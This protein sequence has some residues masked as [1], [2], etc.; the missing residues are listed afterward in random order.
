MPTPTRLV[1][2]VARLIEVLDGRGV[3]LADEFPGGGV[4]VLA[5]R[6]RLLGL[7]P[8]G[9]ASC[10]GAA[11]LF[12]AADGEVVVS[13]ARATDIELL[14]AWAGLM[15]AD[16]RSGSEWDVVDGIVAGRPA[17]S[18]IAAAVELGLP[19]AVVGEVDDRGPAVVDQLGEASPRAVAGAR[20]VNLGA[21]WAAPLAANLLARMGADV[22]A[23]ESATR[24]DGA[25]ATPAFFAALRT[26]TRGVTL[27][28]ESA[29]GRAELL[30]WI[31][32]ADIVIEGSR[33]RALAQ[34]GIAAERLVADA[35]P[36]VWVS[37]TGYGRAGQNG[38]RVGFGDDTAAAGGLVG[39][40]PTAS[41][42]FLADAIGDPLT[43]LTAAAV[44]ADLLERGGRHLADVALARVC[45]T[46]AP[47]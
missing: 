21:L 43:G 27:D 24:P 46:Y 14:P 23:I 41:T 8:S 12:A 5:Q 4:G 29:A 19:C 3:G 28:F 32:D 39:R 18:L 15:G 36:Q 45:A 13:L 11:R 34:F 16:V 20:V 1:E 26:G 9:R 38:M 33:P 17:A 10:G 31:T 22:V 40:T 30:R 25:R 35:G 37:I 2:G 6:A 42:V 44:A 47:D 7:G